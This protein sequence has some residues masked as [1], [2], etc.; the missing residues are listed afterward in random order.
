MFSFADILFLVRQRKQLR[1]EY[2]FTASLFCTFALRL[3][4]GNLWRM[5]RACPIFPFPKF[6]QRSDT[7]AKARPLFQFLAIFF[8]AMTSLRADQVLMQNGDQYFGTVSILTT[9]T[10]ILQS[11]VL[12]TV[13]LPRAKLASITFSTH[14]PSRV[15]EG[16]VPA[17]APVAA[18]ST[19]NIP[20]E[21]PASL[22]KLAAH[23]NL[24]QQVQS[25]FLA[26]A[27]PEANAK[28]NELMN[29]LTSGKLSITDLRAEAKKSVEQLRELQRG[30]GE[31][32][33]SS[34]DAYLSILD[35]FLKE[36]PASS[37][38]NTP[39]AAPQSATKPED[40]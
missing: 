9:N 11:D 23:T 1:S 4:P 17:R 6:A 15:A 18:V 20:A 35:H 28:F 22:R 2:I 13:L 14:V 25:R 12:G 31:D 39:R 32:T 38:T 26:D 29:G 7:A 34:L 27:G 40:E 21:V 37:T 3:F 5:K 19:T 36:T 33:S 30:L 10:L 16:T 24:I 8:L